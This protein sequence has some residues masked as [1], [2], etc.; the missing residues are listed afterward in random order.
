MGYLNKKHD[1]HLK[2]EKEKEKDLTISSNNTRM[3]LIYTSAMSCK[4]YLTLKLIMD[5][6][7]KYY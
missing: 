2:K 6:I 5:C 4:M 3:P 7:C 1:S